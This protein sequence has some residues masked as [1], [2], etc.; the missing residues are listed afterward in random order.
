MIFT[1]LKLEPAQLIEPNLFSDERGYF[2]R[3]FSKDEFIKIGHTKEW[4]QMN[5]SFTSQKGAI[6]GMHYQLS[7]NQE[8][9]LVRCIS[10]SVY[11]V[12]VDMRESSPN[13]LKWQGFVLSANNHKALYIPEG[14][15][16]G[17]QVLETDSELLYMHTARYSKEFEA[18]VRYNDPA[19][20]INW[21]LEVSI[22]S[23]RDKNH[24]LL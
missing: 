15:A 20:G 6:R 12:I 4:V 14:F 21:P 24:P 1:Q 22:V 8:I 3:Y 2:F 19:I 10:G 13:F 7:P 16:H 5:H 18:G 17:F 11:D 23:D 9:K